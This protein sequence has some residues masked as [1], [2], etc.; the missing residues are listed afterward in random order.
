ME[1]S[2]K[3]KRLIKMYAQ[4]AEQGYSRTDGVE[5]KDAFSDFEIRFYRG[6]IK[7]ILL[8]YEVKSILDYG[9]GGADWERENFDDNGQSAKV[10]FSLEEAYKYEPARNIDQRQCVD[11]VICFDVLEHIYIVDIKAIICDL[12]RYAKKLLIINV[13]C[14]SAA[15]KLPNGENAHITVRSPHWWKGVLDSISIDYPDVS[16]LLLC[17]TAWRDTRKFEIW[18]ASEWN[19]GEQFVING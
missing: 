3:G 13:A 8:D 19:N 15:A 2:E 4:M 5:I 14:Y 6:F 10:Y 7:P 18:S 11:C 16:V 1:L 17:S 9:T 12:F